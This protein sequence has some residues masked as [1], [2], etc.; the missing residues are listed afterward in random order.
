VTIPHPSIVE[1]M[2]TVK[3]EWLCMDMEHTAIDFKRGRN[4]IINHSSKWNESI[5]ESE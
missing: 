2:A 1:I 3:F 4:S 5:S